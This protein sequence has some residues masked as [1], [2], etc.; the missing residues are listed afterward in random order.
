MASSSMDKV[1][2]FIRDARKEGVKELPIPLLILFLGKVGNCAVA[3]RLK[4]FL[5]ELSTLRQETVSIGAVI[6]LVGA[7]GSPSPLHESDAE[8]GG[9]PEEPEEPV[10]AAEEQKKL[11]K[12]IECL[13]NKRIHIVRALRLPRVSAKQKEELAPLDVELQ[14]KIHG[15]VIYYVL[16]CDFI[17]CFVF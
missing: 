17:D 5:E 2:G 14:K 16:Y 10:R 6:A 4:T 15:I 3:S 12:E 1:M 11:R 13:L 9:A 7:I 8:E